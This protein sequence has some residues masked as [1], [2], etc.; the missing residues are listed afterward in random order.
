MISKNRSHQ[1]AIKFGKM[2]TGQDRPSFVKLYIEVPG[3]ESPL[4]RRKF[5]KWDVAK[6]APFGG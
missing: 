1:L 3:A 6:S 5:Q 2:L 4:F